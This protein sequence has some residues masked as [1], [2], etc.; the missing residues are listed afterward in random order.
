[1]PH[2]SMVVWADGTY[3]VCCHS[4][5]RYP[6]LNQDSD[7]LN[8][9]VQSN[10]DIEMIKEMQSNNLAHINCMKCNENLGLKVHEFSDNLF[11]REELETLVQTPKIKYLH[12]SPTR[13]C[14]LACRTCS[15]AFS[16]T[17]E[18]T[19]VD[20]P[21]CKVSS[22]EFP[23]EKT[24][25]MIDSV[26]AD[27]K[28]FTFHGGEPLL[29][30]GFYEILDLISTKNKS[31]NIQLI[32]NGSFDLKKLGILDKLKNFESVEIIFSLDGA[33]GLN[34]MIRTFANTDSI[35]NNI[36]N[37]YS[38]EEYKNI[39]II[40]HTTFS[41][42]NILFIA[43]LIDFFKK[44]KYSEKGVVFSS[45][46]LVDPFEYSID[47]FSKN[48]RPFIIEYLRNNL[49]GAEDVF[50]KEIDK[51]ILSLISSLENKSPLPHVFRK[52]LVSN[53]DFKDG[54]TNI[55]LKTLIEDRIK[56]LLEKD[57]DLID[58]L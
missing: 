26:V 2:Y 8:E 50:Y 15:S 13:K 57:G 33:K 42:F 19:F 29:Y 46:I 55:M 32:T 35:L 58:L 44:N 17:F 18:K 5:R 37:I 6:L 3:S 23:V 45:F 24:L 1:M 52:N 53:L 38:S 56:K 34:E 10:F 22:N 25:N 27:L 54:K 20:S 30:S 11:T 12:F 49:I 41:V 36:D 9:I 47:V 16:S 31:C 43:E 4:K 28:N 48:I 51:L 39:K 40:S 21:E 7:D 14:N